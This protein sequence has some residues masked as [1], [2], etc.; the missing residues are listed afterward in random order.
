[1]RLYK[2]ELYKICS[3]K[4]FL[5]SA[6]AAFSILLLYMYSY[7]ESSTTT[8]NGVKYTGYQAIK[9]DRQITAKYSG[10]LTDEKIRDIVENYGFP[11]GV[12]ER[13]YGFVDSNYLN[14]FIMEFFSDGYFQGYDNYQVATRTYPIAETELGQA[15]AAVG[16][17][18]QLEY[19]YGWQIF[20]D[21]LSIG[22]LLGMVLILLSLSPVY[23]DESYQNT[24]Q[25]LF[26]TKEGKQKDIAAKIA[27]GMTVAV[28][29]F[30]VIVL[31]DF[32]YVAS[33]YG[34]N[35]GDCFSCQIIG[36]EFLSAY[37]N[38]QNCST[39]GGMYYI[40]YYIF[41]CFLGFVE[42]AA[43]SL[44]FSSHC[45]SP[46]QAIILS[47]MCLF[48]P[49]FLNLLGR[50]NFRG[51]VFLLS[52]LSILLFPGIA[53]MSLVPDTLHPM[54]YRI[55]KVL[56]C[57][58]PMLVGQYFRYWF[59]FYYSVPVLLFANGVVRDLDFIKYHEG[60]S[61]VRQGVFGFVIAVSVLYLI[62]SWQKYKNS[63]S[64]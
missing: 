16:K 41:E 25:L 48:V 17:P 1:M 59:P 34:L 22:A 58:L 54:V 46:F 50:D 12:E 33:F 61:W 2:M 53:L 14:T 39:W 47:V 56:C 63:Y 64:S 4:L 32:L 15:S 43:V 24:Q 40:V 29:I 21:I 23:A 9:M 30:A 62:C 13:H 37:H 31:L 38:Y 60:F 5:F 3:K 49:V 11:S 20:Y 26:T 6:A 35:G 8:I 19:T 52:Q 55:G 18:L 45:K 7:V 27:A 10:V 51:I 57:V 44:Y 42:V 36:D 28:G